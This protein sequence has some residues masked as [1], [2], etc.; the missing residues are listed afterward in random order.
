MVILDPPTFAGSEAELERATRAY[1]DI[2]LP[3]LN[4]GPGR[5][6]GSFPAPV[7][8]CPTC[9]RRSSS[10]PAR[11][12][13]SAQILARLGQGADHPMLLSFRRGST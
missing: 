4:Y 8:L 1:K 2:H 12:P 5:A 10:A 13:A 3:V 7:W 11:M 6:A 9:S